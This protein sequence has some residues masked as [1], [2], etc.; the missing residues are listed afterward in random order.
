MQ[1]GGSTPGDVWYRLSPIRFIVL[2]ILALGVVILISCAA[3]ISSH[4][5]AAG[6]AQYQDAPV[7]LP[8]SAIFGSNRRLWRVVSTDDHV[9]VDYSTDY[10]KS[11]SPPVAV[12][13]ER[14]PIRSRSEYRSQIVVDKTGR[15][16]VA[17]PAYGQQPWTTYLSVSEDNGRHFSIPEPLS[18]QAGVAN[19][20]EAT[21]A[22]DGQDCLHAFWHDERESASEET[23]NAIYFSVRDSTGRLLESNRNLAQGVCSC[24]RL[25]LDFDSDGQPVLLYRNI[26]P[27]N[28]RDHE[29]AKADAAG[30]WAKSRVSE[31]EWRIQACPTDGPALAIGTD[32]RYHIAWFTQ[33]SVRQG[34]FYANSSDRGQHFSKPMPI[35]SNQDQLPGHPAVI[36]L[37]SR[38]ILTWSEFDGISTRIM[39]LQSH[40]RGNRWSQARS[41]AESTSESDYPFLLSD[42][43]GIFL[44]WNSQIEGYRLIPIE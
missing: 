25:A 32:G 30:G 37:G 31:D 22:I 29:L 13:E 8:V 1:N 23:G 40:D 28:I 43:Q 21:L 20:F 38:V 2:A 39:I 24:C 19:S 10:G 5:S 9:Y 12:N 6:Y 14:I 42:G 33:G 15:I 7:K 3:G 44:S 35:G 11:F 18:D 36:S 41:V 17:Y 27:G 26:Y 34:L 16:Y 4:Q